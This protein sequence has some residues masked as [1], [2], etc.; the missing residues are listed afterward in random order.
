[1]T[2]D[3]VAESNDDTVMLG[4]CRGAA[5]DDVPLRAVLM[6]LEASK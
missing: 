5:R 4:P 2:L 6:S 3:D 1:M